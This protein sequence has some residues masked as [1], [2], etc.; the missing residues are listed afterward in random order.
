MIWL[1][2]IKMYKLLNDEFDWITCA[3][4]VF[5]IIVLGLY[6]ERCWNWSFI[7]M[8]KR[9]MDNYNLSVDEWFEFEVGFWMTGTTQ[10]H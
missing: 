6:L 9:G 5:L 1:L 4:R 3:A 10:I 7:I 8:C 2:M